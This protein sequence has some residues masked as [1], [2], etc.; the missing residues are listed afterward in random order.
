MQM[1]R[2]IIAVIAVSISPETYGLGE[3]EDGGAKK[4]QSHWELWPRASTL[5]V[6]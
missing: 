3:S 6:P 2:K 5:S 1:D 4:M